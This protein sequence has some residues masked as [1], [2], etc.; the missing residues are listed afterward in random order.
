[1]LRSLK[2]ANIRTPDSDTGFWSWRT[3]GHRELAGRPFTG[4][5]LMRLLAY[6]LVSAGP[7]P[8]FPPLAPAA[9]RE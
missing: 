1:M 3:S 2:K 7:T 8:A 9:F 6:Q 4:G 5:R